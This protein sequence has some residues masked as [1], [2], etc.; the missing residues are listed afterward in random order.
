MT[1]SHPCADFPWSI[2]PLTVVGI[3]GIVGIVSVPKRSAFETS[4]RDLSE[5][6]SFD[7]STLLDIEQSISGIE[8]SSLEYR[9]RGV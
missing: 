6:V 7:T 8:Q 9:P 1:L 3:V 4:R 5:D 2:S